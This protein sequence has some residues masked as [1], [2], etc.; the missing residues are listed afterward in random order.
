VERVKA[1]Q[2]D[3]APR[4]AI[5]EFE[6]D[7]IA[8]RVGPDAASAFPLGFLVV[9]LIDGMRLLVWRLRSMRSRR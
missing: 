6:S 3:G 9:L 2:Q 7:S 8:G 4:P 5:P 1:D